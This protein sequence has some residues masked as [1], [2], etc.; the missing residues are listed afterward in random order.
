MVDVDA[1][2][3]LD[4]SYRCTGRRRRRAV[5]LNMT[6]SCLARSRCRPARR[7]VDDRG[8]VG[9][10]RRR[11]LLRSAETQQD[12]RVGALAAV[13]VLT[14]DVVAVTAWV[15][16]PMISMLMGPLLGVV[17][18]RHATRRPAP[19]TMS[20]PR[21]CCRSSASARGRRRWRVSIATTSWFPDDRQPHRAA[22]FAGFTGTVVLGHPGIL[23]PGGNRTAGTTEAAPSDSRQNDR[24]CAR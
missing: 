15:S 19:G 21:G 6:A 4:G 13:G 14:V 9:R 16:D 10:S 5:V 18:P 7:A 23:S 17:G 8:S 3:L 11:R 24:P 12:H 20:W 22:V 2:Q 1:R